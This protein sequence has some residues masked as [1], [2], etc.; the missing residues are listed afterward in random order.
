MIIMNGDDDG[1]CLPRDVLEKSN[2][3]HTSYMVKEPSEKA[4]TMQSD[5]NFWFLTCSFLQTILIILKNIL[6]H[7]H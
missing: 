3:D 5:G 4:A 6:E 7:S 2:E 1:G